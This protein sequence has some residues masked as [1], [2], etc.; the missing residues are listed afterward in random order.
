MQL[1]VHTPPG[2]ASLK[3]LPNAVTIFLKL[4]L[5]V[6]ELSS[7]GVFGRFEEQA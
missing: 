3:L 5:A 7:T 1:S 4:P 2:A 6:P